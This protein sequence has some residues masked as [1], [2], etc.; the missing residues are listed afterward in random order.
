MIEFFPFSWENFICISVSLRMMDRH[1]SRD[2]RFACIA[3]FCG[4]LTLLT[5]SFA[6][7]I[8]CR[9]GSERLW[10]ASMEKGML[11]HVKVFGKHLKRLQAYRL[12]G[13]KGLCKWS[14]RGRSYL[15]SPL[16]AWIN[17]K[18]AIEMRINVTMHGLCSETCQYKSH[19]CGPLHS[20]QPQT[21]NEM[22]TRWKS[23]HS[24]E[25]KKLFHFIFIS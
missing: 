17:P 7:L 10:M 5:S 4:E 11:D 16:F 21:I 19:S 13:S 18:A 23:R 6:E 14:V 2:E 22:A 15:I 25:T 20:N 24:G 3:V 12:A 1:W 8:S 9:I